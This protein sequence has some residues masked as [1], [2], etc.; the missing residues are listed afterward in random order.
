MHPASLVTISLCYLY[1]WKIIKFKIRD[2]QLAK[3]AH[4]RENLVEKD[5]PM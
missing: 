2:M 5:N 1:K 4:R 3:L